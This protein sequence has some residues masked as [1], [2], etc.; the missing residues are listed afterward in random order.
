MQRQ[1]PES[2]PNNQSWWLGACVI[3]FVRFMLCVEMHHDQNNTR[4]RKIGMKRVFGAA[5]TLKRHLFALSQHATADDSRS[6][7]SLQQ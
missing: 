1:F 5:C 2:V 3:A 6:Y 7:E 4:C